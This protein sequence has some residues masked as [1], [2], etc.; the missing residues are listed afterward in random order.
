MQSMPR[1]LIVLILLLGLATPVVGWASE[2][3][4]QSS[5]LQTS[6]SGTVTNVGHRDVGDQSMMFAATDQR[7]VDCD[8]DGCDNGGCND[9][10]CKRGCACGCDMGT[11]ASSCVAYFGQLSAFPW[12]PAT[13]TIAPFIAQQPAVAH[14]ATP[15]RPPIV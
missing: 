9:G 14:G 1:I 12:V 11:C 2:L 3:N 13:A 5:S 7:D 10:H 4:G 6:Q 8:D 15:L